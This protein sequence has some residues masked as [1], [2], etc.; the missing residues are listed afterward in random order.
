M[1]V[2]ID[3]SSLE[4]IQRRINALVRLSE[5]ESE[6][7]S[8]TLDN[9]AMREAGEEIIA[10]GEPLDRPFFVVTGWAAR[11]SILPDG[12]RQLIDFYIPGDLAACSPRP[13][14][15]AKASY[16]CLTNMVT[17]GAAHLVQAV[18]EMPSRYPALAQALLAM[19]EEGEDRLIA[20]ISRIGRMTA[21]E[22]MTDLLSELQF[23]HQRVGIGLGDGFVMPL[24]QDA[25]GDALGLSTVH[26]NRVLKELRRDH[27]IRTSARQIVVSGD[28][29]R[30]MH[31]AATL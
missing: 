9:P 16:V 1:A 20:Q 11:A 31:G 5:T 26:V 15:H 2:A 23:R 18:R 8:R 3:R 30:M 19:E 24:T 7:L 27:T 21:R 29:T 13:R 25:L 4:V 10:A 28:D 17:A 12:Q 14:T 22:R 6:F